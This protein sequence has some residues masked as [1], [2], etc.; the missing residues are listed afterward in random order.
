L[1]LVLLIRNEKATERAIRNEKL[2]Y[3]QQPLRYCGWDNDFSNF[4]H[5]QSETEILGPFS[6]INLS[7]LRMACRRP[8][9]AGCL[10]KVP[11]CRGWLGLSV[12][13]LISLWVFLLIFAR[14]Q[15]LA[16]S[17]F[18]IYDEKGSKSSISDEDV[19]HFQ[20]FAEMRRCSRSFSFMH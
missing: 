4:I 13:I 9:V 6:T 16:A 5:R 18:F 17:S 20:A 15:K 7:E 1:D 14:S 11:A 8:A 10:P 19:T 12:R 3:F 2:I